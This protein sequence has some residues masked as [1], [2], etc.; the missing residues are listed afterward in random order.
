MIFPD[1]E[2][3]NLGWNDRGSSPLVNQSL[4]LRGPKEMRFTTAA[5][6][7][8][9]V[10]LG[11]WRWVHPRNCVV[12]ISPLFDACDCP[13]SRSDKTPLPDSSSSVDPHQVG[14]PVAHSVGLPLSACPL[15]GYHW[16]GWDR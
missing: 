16:V 9:A 13:N 4:G 3:G 7:L 14:N 15:A 6:V 10:D 1:S 12:V 8:M 2:E 5:A 11:A